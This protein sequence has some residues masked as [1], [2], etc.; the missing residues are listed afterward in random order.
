MG[1]TDYNL[2]SNMDRFI[3]R[4]LRTSDYQYIDLKSNMDRF[5]APPH[6]SM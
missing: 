6:T 4:D 1:H 3:V 5:I 2:K